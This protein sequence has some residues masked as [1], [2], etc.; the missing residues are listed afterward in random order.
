MH[1][2]GCLWCVMAAVESWDSMLSIGEQQ[3]LAFAR[4]LY[5]KPKY[6]LMVCQIARHLLATSLPCLQLPCLCVLYCLQDEATSALDVD[7]QKRVMGLVMQ[8]GIT[9]ISV[10]HRPSLVLFHQDMLRLDGAG[11]CVCGSVVRALGV[12][13]PHSCLACC[14]QVPLRTGG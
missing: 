13:I 14:W 3:R 9:P 1:N 8:A 5:H 6:A 7:M 12:H 2:R 4:L 11:G 10:A